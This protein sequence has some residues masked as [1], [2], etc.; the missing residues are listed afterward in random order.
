MRLFKPGDR[1]KIK[2]Y[3]VEKSDAMFMPELQGKNGIVV[4][5]NAFNYPLVEVKFLKRDL[6]QKY[7][8]DK[9][10]YTFIYWELKLLRA[11]CGKGK[12][13]DPKKERCIKK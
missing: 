3:D 9:L 4:S 8:R 12:T 2:K 11:G 1:V 6:P 13:W 5:G 7:R 10:P